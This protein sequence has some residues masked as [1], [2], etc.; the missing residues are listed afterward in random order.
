M[1]FQYPVT[2]KVGDN[3]VIATFKDVPEAITFG[4]DKE[5]ALYESEDALLVAL[6]MYVDDKRPI[7]APSKPSKGQS[8]V[9]VPP[10]ATAKIALHNALLE[11][12][13][14]KVAL[15]Q[16]MGLRETQVRR[17]LDLDH[18]S[19]IAQIQTALRILG[20]EVVTSVKKVA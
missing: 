11:A 7:P 3:E 17:M 9:A 4:D 5:H 16:K 1:E 18:Q 15:A 8:M 2:L 12:N 19:H 14:S 6:A 20:Y 13:M 10:L